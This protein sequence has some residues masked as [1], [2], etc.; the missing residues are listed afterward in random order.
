MTLSANIFRGALM[1]SSFAF[2]FVFAPDSVAFKSF[3]TFAKEAAVYVLTV[4]I[5]MAVVYAVV[6]L[7]NVYTFV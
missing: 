1:I 3:R 7:V 2:V 5:H 6:T 4:S